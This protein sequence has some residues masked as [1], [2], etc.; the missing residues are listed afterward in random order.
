MNSS[1]SLDLVYRHASEILNFPSTLWTKTE[2][3]PFDVLIIVE[4]VIN[5]QILKPKVSSWLSACVEVTIRSFDIF[6]TNFK[7]TILELN[8]NHTMQIIELSS[9]AVLKCKNILILG[10]YV[11]FYLVTV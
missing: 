7:S 11:F 6:Q 1:D 3:I 4:N 2:E 8:N 5:S 10:I 9:D